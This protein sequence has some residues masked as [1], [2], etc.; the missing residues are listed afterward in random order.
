VNVIHCRSAA[1]P[2]EV[3]PP[4]ASAPAVAIVWPLS[5]EVDVAKPLSA[6]SPLYAYW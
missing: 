4:F 2:F 5:A 3:M 1:T 6:P